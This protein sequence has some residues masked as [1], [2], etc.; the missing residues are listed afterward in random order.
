MRNSPFWWI[1]IGF[2]VLVDIYFFQA[3]KAVSHGASQRTRAIIYISYWVISIAAIVVLLLLPYMQG[4]KQF[5]FFKSSLL[6]LLR[7]CFLP[8]WWPHCFFWLTI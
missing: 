8:N 2:M 6:P 3:L 4:D 5:R 7:V 1:L